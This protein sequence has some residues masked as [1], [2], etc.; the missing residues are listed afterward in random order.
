MPTTDEVLNKKRAEVQE[1]RDWIAAA[2]I[3]KARLTQ[4]RQNDVTAGQLDAEKDSLKA[5]MQTVWQEVES[6]GGDPEQIRVEEKKIT[7]SSAAAAKSTVES[8]S[9]SS[10]MEGR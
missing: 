10:N 9:K 8:A 6:L 1:L 5:Q 3:E 7:R 4:E 2:E